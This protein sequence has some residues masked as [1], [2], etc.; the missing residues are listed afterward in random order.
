MATI[1]GTWYMGSI[2]STLPLPRPRIEALHRAL[3]IGA[4][5]LLFI[6]LALVVAGIRI[7]RRKQIASAGHRSIARFGLLGLMVTTA[8]A[9]VAIRFPMATFLMTVVLPVVLLVV[10]GCVAALLYPIAAAVDWLRRP[11]PVNPD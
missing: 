5:S 6:P 1:V 8:I 7:R 9:A 10:G 3:L 2:L 4:A 11:R